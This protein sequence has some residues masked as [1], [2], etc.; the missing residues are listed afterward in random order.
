MWNEKHICVL[1]NRKE[2]ILSWTGHDGV[3]REHVL[4]DSEYAHNRRN[5]PLRNWGMPK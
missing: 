3:L 4:V 2:V 5:D 1:K